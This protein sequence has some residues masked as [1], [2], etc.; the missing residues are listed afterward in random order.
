MERDASN[1]GAAS[2]AKGWSAL[3]NGNAKAPIPT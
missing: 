1:G 2:I 3:E